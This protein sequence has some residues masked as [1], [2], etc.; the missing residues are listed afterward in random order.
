LTPQR[1]ATATYPIIRE[2]L[3]GSRDALEAAGI[4]WATVPKRECLLNMRE[5]GRIGAEALLQ[6]HPNITAPVCQTEQIALGALD[7]VRDR[8][9]SVVGFDDIP[10]RSRPI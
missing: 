2:R 7:H 5:E 6:R 3:G 10:P 4:D 9:T 1:E 8:G